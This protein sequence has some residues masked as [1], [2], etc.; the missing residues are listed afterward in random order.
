MVSEG[1]MGNRPLYP[2]SVVAELI[3]VHP[4]TIRAW[5]KNGVIQPARRSGKRFYSTNDLKR[6][7]FIQQL[8][9]EGLN[10][11]AIR[12]HLKLY[13]CWYSD[14]CPNCVHNSDGLSCGKPCW[15][16]EGTL[17]QVWATEDLCLMCEFN[18]QREGKQ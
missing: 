6:L 8:T 15:K 2:I 4:A 12:Y 5:E 16:D 7:Q 10:L 17:C 1:S 13:P 11:P 14:G 3:N 9:Q 18:P